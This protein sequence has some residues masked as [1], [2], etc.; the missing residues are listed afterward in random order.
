MG[1]F[2]DLTQPFYDGMPGFS[3][4][5]PDGRRLDCTAHIREALSH[6]ESAAFYDGQCAFAYT[7]ARFF[8]SIGTRLDAPYIRW[9][10]KRDIAKLAL[11]DVVLPGWVVDARGMAPETALTPEAAALP[12]EPAIPE[13]RV[14]R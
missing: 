3:L 7:E 12:D 13:Q 4:T 6:A 1:A 9:P 10:E 11:D 2:V 5:Q 14:E 8:T